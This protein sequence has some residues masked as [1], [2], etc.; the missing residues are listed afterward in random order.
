MDQVQEMPREAIL[1]PFPWS[2][3]HLLEL[4]DEIVDHGLHLRGF[5]GEEDQLLV[6]QVE[7]QHVVGGDGHEQDIGVAGSGGKDGVKEQ[8]RRAQLRKPQGWAERRGGDWSSRQT[9]GRTKTPHASPMHHALQPLG[10]GCLPRTWMELSGDKES[11]VLARRA[12]LHG[13]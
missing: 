7:L 8:A 1:A 5:G 13:E 11:G 9:K 3:S 2:A 6:G 12:E 4:C 10:S